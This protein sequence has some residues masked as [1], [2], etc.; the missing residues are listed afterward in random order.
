MRDTRRVVRGIGITENDKYRVETDPD[1]IAGMYSQAE[2]DN[3]VESGVLSADDPKEWKST[4]TAEGGADVS[5]PKAAGKG[6]ESHK[7]ASK[8]DGK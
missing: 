1:A 4:K 2:L 5:E 3:F 6:A 7:S 8:K